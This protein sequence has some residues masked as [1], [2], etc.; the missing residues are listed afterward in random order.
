M[1]AWLETAVASG[2]LR[3]TVAL[4]PSLNPTGHRAKTR[5]PSFQAVDPVTKLAHE[6]CWWIA[7]AIRWAWSAA[8][9]VR[10]R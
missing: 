8:C 2:E 1:L 3:G 4:Y 5:S 10:C 9:C 7:A 6:T